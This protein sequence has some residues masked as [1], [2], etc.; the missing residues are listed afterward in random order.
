MASKATREKDSLPTW[1]VVVILVGFV[2]LFVI[3]GDDLAN[4]LRRMG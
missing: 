2:L 4:A 3:G 1:A